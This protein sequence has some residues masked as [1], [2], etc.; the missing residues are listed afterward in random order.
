M[1]PHTHL[2]TFLMLAAWLLPAAT[3]L[4]QGLMS[5]AHTLGF[6]HDQLA[7]EVER[8]PGGIRATTT[9]ADENLLE[10]LRRHPRDMWSHLQAGGAVRMWDPLF[11]EIVQHHEAVEMT[12]VDVPDGIRVEVTTDDPEV[13]K[14]IVAHAAKVSDFVER[15]PAAMR[16]STPLPDDY[17]PSAAPAQRGPGR[18]CCNSRGP[19]ARRG[20][21]N[22]PRRE[23]W[24]SG[25][26]GRGLGPR[27]QAKGR[28][29]GNG[30]RQDGWGNGQGGWG[31][32]G[33]LGEPPGPRGRG[34]GP[35]A[36]NRGSCCQR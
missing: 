5:D 32:R 35:G 25:K 20:Q 26:G 14:L 17:T 13:E 6:N 15:G 11:A 18:G 33:P 21:G 23:D 9:T 8:I 22:G 2:R 12:F 30:P 19:Q 34:Q 28:G 1:K 31:R 7:R 10:A 24:G 29:P 36:G 27:A 3:V 4:A 16:E